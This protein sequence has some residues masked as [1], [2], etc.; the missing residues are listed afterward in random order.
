MSDNDIAEIE[1]EFKESEDETLNTSD[2]T[3]DIGT[4]HHYLYHSSGYYDRYYGDLFSLSSGF[5]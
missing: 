2:G 5:G 3:V 1:D 4:I